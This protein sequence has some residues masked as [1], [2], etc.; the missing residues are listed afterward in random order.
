MVCNEIAPSEISREGVSS[1]Y[2]GS[3]IAARHILRRKPRPESDHRG[4]VAR[5]AGR[6]PEVAMRFGPQDDRS[7]SRPHLLAHTRRAA[8]LAPSHECIEHLDPLGAA[9]VGDLIASTR[10]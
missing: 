3:M 7:A 8:P 5:P 10:P 9:K 4:V 6:Y 2:I 1:S